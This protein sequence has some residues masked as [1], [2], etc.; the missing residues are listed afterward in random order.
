MQK[1]FPWVAVALASL[2]CARAPESGAPPSG[3][4][5]S[6]AEAPKSGS[7]ID[8]ATARRLVAAGATLV[9]VRSPSEFA[10][11]HAPGALNIPVSDL[12]RRLADVPVGRPVVVYC[13]SGSRSASATRTL[14]S[15]GYEVFDLQRL[16]NWP[17]E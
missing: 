6:A 3:A 17:A 7:V 8:G 15:G 1:F 9:D 14:L 11:G 10:A 12:P 13:R 4:V 16:T 2:A 5:A